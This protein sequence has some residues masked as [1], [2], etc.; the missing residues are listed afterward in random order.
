LQIAPTITTTLRAVWKNARSAAVT[1][2]DRPWVQ[3]SIRP[4]TARGFG[5]GS[6]EFSTAVPRG[7]LVRA[8]FPL[9]Q[10]RPC[11]LA[12]CSNQIRTLELRAQRGEELVAA[13][14]NGPARGRERP[15]IVR[16]GGVGTED[17]VDVVDEAGIAEAA[18][19]VLREV[20][21]GDPLA[22]PVLLDA[23]VGQSRLV[24]RVARVGRALVEPD[25]VDA[26]VLRRLLVEDVLPDPTGA[27]DT[28]AS[29]GGE[30]D[31][32]ARLARVRL[33]VGAQLQHVR[34][35]A[36]ALGRRGA[37]CGG[38]VVAAARKCEQCE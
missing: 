4:R 16:P 34:E 2:R 26:Q 8:V 11:Y 31:D 14:D 36:D 15:G 21:S 19:V 12:G 3:L 22:V 13:V 6:A 20:G 38:L 23:R 5:F 7:T 33:E 17:V 9:S 32:H 27:G 18:E 28:R 35:L 24:D 29:S 1:V 30:E 10:A 25:C 37:G